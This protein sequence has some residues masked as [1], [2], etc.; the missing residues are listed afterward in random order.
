M[1]KLTSLD[2]LITGQVLTSLTQIAI[3]VSLLITLKYWR[4]L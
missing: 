1:Y 2:T 4:S 3:L